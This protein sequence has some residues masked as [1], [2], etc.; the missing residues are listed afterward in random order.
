[1][2]W[3]GQLRPHGNGQKGVVGMAFTLELK[4][5]NAAF[6]DDDGN[7][8]AGPEIARILREIADKYDSGIYS[9]NGPA[10]PVFDV[11]GNRI[12]QYRL[13]SL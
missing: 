8:E 1:M 13:S 3:L 2:C 7:P 9:T 10:L 4:T 11:N 6:I 5:D 12:G